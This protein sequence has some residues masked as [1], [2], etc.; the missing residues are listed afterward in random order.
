MPH[1]YVT[2]R[3]AKEWGVPPWVVRDTPGSALWVHYWL[4]VNR[5]EG[6]IAEYRKQHANPR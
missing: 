3:V 5:I 1:D 6:S 2:L 4:A